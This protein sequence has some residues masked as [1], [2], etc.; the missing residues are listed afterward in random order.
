[1][2]N[3]ATRGWWGLV[4]GLLGWGWASPASAEVWTF[5]FQKGED[6][7]VRCERTETDASAEPG[8]LVVR[9]EKTAEA[10]GPTL[11]V[12][13]EPGGGQPL[14]EEE[15]AFVLALPRDK[16]PKEGALQVEAGDVACE[17]FRAPGAGTEAQAPAVRE[18]DLEA[19]AWW[20][21][22]GRKALGKLRGELKFPRNTRFLV[23]YLNGERAAPA[24]QSLSEREPA[25][26]VVI[27][28]A[29][30][31]LAVELVVSTCEDVQPFRVTRPEPARL[32]GRE[33]RREWMLVP[34][35]PLL[36]CGEGTLAYTLRVGGEEGGG[37]RVRVR[38]VHNVSATVVYGFDF[39]KEKRFAVVDGRVTEEADATGLGVRLGVT[40][41]LPWGMDYEE[42][43]WHNHFANLVFAV[44]PEAPTERFVTGLGLTPTGGLSL[45][46][47]VSVHR[48]TAL[49]GGL[50]PGAEFTGVGEVPTRR[51]WRAAGVRPFIGLSLDDDI[52]TVFQQRFGGR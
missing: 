9:V 49:G 44:D 32:E 31:G 24:E 15:D 41:Y 29:R 5:R 34:V 10:V 30:A 27:A 48:V 46:V 26:V 19:L 38:P 20:Q 50:T 21:R 47:G 52:F 37:T 39:V 28:D 1:M 12:E 33:P 18:Q 14:G 7:S 40:W 6:G 51:E 8:R 43:R 36:R 23:H 2:K 11:K 3:Y 17:P 25:Q 35:G 4:V 13:G 45:L 16:L 42:L 22:E